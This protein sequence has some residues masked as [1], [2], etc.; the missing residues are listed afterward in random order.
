[1]HFAKTPEPDPQASKTGKINS[2]LARMNLKQDQHY[3]E[4]PLTD[5]Y[6]NQSKFSFFIH[7]LLHWR[8]SCFNKTVMKIEDWQRVRW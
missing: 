5:P 1:M 7:F 6:Q 4:D 2:L 8:K 3:V